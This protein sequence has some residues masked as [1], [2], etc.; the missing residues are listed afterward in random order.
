MCPVPKSWV[1]CHVLCAMPCA[2]CWALCHAVCCAMGCL[3][4]AVHCADVLFALHYLPCTTCC[5][6]CAVYHAL[7]AMCCVLFAMCYVPCAV[8]C[9][10]HAM[11][12]MPCSM[13][14][15]TAVRP[16]PCPMCPHWGCVPWQCAVTGLVLVAVPACCGRVPVPEQCC[17]AWGC[18]WQWAERSAQSI[19]FIAPDSS[20]SSQITDVAIETRWGCSCVWPS[21]RA[22]GAETPTRAASPP[23]VWG[24]CCR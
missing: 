3:L 4:C 20:Q 15:A 13:R 21:V 2:V 7:C 17:G 22:G 12:C 5:M 8:R 14:S 6:P 9:V 19:I 11:R 23:W 24:V 1:L 18:Y 10:P 16:Q